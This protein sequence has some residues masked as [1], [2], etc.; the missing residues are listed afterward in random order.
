MDIIKIFE[1]IRE[2]NKSV[3]RS[4]SGSY[5]LFY[6]DSNNDN[7]T[8]LANYIARLL[9]KIES[10]YNVLSI[11]KETDNYTVSNFI[12]ELS[13][14]KDRCD[15]GAVYLFDVTNITPEEE[16]MLQH[17]NAKFIDENNVFDVL[18]KALNASTVYRDRASTIL[19]NIMGIF[20]HIINGRVRVDINASIDIL[21]NLAEET[22]CNERVVEEYIIRTVLN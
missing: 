15:I 5:L 11:S 1:K 19:A 3:S 16:V 10:K 2:H 12:K 17:Y 22:L 9:Y 4:S 8:I 14:Y 13:L 6:Y 20:F 18:D 21:D 7:F